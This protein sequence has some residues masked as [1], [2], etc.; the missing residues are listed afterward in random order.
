MPEHD[1]RIMSEICMHPDTQIGIQPVSI[2]LQRSA[3]C[4]VPDGRTFLLV[5]HSRPKFGNHKINKIFLSRRSYF[6]GLS[7]SPM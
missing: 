3:D 1:G 2:P 5:C 7:S 4:I 6:V